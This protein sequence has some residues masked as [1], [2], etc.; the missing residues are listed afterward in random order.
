LPEHRVEPGVH[1][2]VHAPPTHADD[3]QALGLTQVP[4][5]EQVSTLFPEHRVE[6]GAHTPVQLPLTHA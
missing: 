4:L 1:T 5:V 6:F 3:T 2:P